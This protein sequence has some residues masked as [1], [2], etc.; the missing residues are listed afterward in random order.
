[1]NFY[2]FS[3]NFNIMYKAVITTTNDKGSAYKIRD[4]L[5][6]NGVSPC[7]QIIDR[8]NSAYVWNERVRNDIEYMLIVKCK[9][10]NI[11]KVNS[12]IASKHNYKTPEIISIDF[13]IISKSYRNWFD[14]NS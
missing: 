11:K 7:V 12:T 3:N 8:V 13:D 5:L 4:A 1:V 14:R 2:Y 10:K 6:L 9:S